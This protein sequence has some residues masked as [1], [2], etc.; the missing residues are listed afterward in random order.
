MKLKD[1][2]SLEGKL[3]KLP[4]PEDFLCPYCRGGHSSAGVKRQAPRLI[5]SFLGLPLLTS[6]TPVQVLVTVGV[7]ILTCFFPS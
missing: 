6:T 2:Y 4:N 1:A 7:K 3:P 5:E